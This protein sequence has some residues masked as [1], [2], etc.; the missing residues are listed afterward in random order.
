MNIVARLLR[1]NLSRAQVAG[2]V[3]SN[4]IGLAIVVAGIQ[5]YQDLGSICICSK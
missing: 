1:K 5:L 2:F 3:I 4:F